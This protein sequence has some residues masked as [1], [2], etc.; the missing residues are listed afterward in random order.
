MKFTYYFD[1]EKTHTIEFSFEV[2]NY[3]VADNG[4]VS[5]IFI[6]RVTERANEQVVRTESKT[7]SFLFD[8]KNVG[9]DIDLLRIRLAEQN[10][11]IFHIKNNKDSKQDVIVGLITK[12]ATINPLGEDISHPTTSYNAELKANNVAMLE[13]TYQPPVLTQ[14][15]VY[16]TFA[17]PEY[18]IGFKSDTAIYNPQRMMY[19]L[20]NFKQVLLQEIDPYTAFSIEMNVAPL[21]VDSAIDTIFVVYID[22]LGKFELQ[23]EYLS[24]I[25]EGHPTSERQRIPI[26]YNLTPE[27]FYRNNSFLSGSKLTLSGNGIGKLTITYLDKQY[28]VNYDPGHMI[29]S[30]ALETKEQNATMKMMAVS[31]FD[32]T[33]GARVFSSGD[34][35]GIVGEWDAKNIIDDSTLTA[36]GSIQAGNVDGLAWI[37]LDLLTAR[38]V[39]NITLQQNEGAGVD[40]IDVETSED[41]NTWTYVQSANT[42]SQGLVS[43]DLSVRAIARYWRLIARSPIV[44]FPDNGEGWDDRLIDESWIIY[45]V[46]LYEAETEE[47]PAPEDLIVS[48]IDTQTVKLK[49]NYFGPVNSAFR[50][51]SYGVYMGTEVV[52]ENEMIITNLLP[53]KN[54][55]FQV[56]ASALNKISPVSNLAKIDLEDTD[57]N[58][59]NRLKVLFDNFIVKFYK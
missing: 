53:G 37:A 28:I 57:I 49:W 58:W 15:L 39:R 45:D 10:K 24:F 19:E 13:Q 52:G 33:P 20:K 11:W 46:A 25:G 47:L 50:V 21:S 23:K 6:A 12:T 8:S 30:I 42:Y 2:Q 9:H 41:G 18:P 27:A 3:Q 55:G 29:R 43:I 14:T 59:E 51:Y 32:I 4:N 48:V 34:R 1:T 22:G 31:D 36:W 56:T 16:T 7:G 35:L 5:I 40:L 17:T 44:S 38:A 26:G 54:Y